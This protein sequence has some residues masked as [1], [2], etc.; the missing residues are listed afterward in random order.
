[1]PYEGKLKGLIIYIRP[2][3]GKVININSP[4]ATMMMNK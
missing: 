2:P 4:T 1:M 3:R